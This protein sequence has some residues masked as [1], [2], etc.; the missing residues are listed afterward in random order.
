MLLYN[1]P[2]PLFHINQ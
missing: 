2:V 1:I